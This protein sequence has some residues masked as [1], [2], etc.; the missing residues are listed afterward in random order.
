MKSNVADQLQRYESRLLSRFTVG[1]LYPAWP[2]DIK[3]RS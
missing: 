1:P 2:R 3:V